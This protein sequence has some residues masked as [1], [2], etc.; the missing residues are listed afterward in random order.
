MNEVQ[1]NLT[2]SLANH[3]LDGERVP[4]LHDAV[5]LVVLVVQYVGVGVEKRP[6]TVPTLSRMGRG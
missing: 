2:G 3:G 5:R 6:D 1:N 4:L